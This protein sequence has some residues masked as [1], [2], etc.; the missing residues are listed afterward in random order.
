MNDA[1]CGENGDA[2][3]D[4]NRGLNCGDHGLL[5]SSA[6]LPFYAMMAKAATTGHTIG[7][8][9]NTDPSGLQ[10]TEWLSVCKRWTKG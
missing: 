5:L 10:N 3:D 9:S 8:S 7:C 1:N 6:R 4:V 2:S